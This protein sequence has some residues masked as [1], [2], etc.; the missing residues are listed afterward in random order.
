L[1]SGGHLDR[2]FVAMLLEFPGYRNKRIAPIKSID[3]IRLIEAIYRA[4]ISTQCDRS[5]ASITL[6]PSAAHRAVDAKHAPGG[7]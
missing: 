4:E 5:S 7:G 2:T 6:I 3:P 1:Q